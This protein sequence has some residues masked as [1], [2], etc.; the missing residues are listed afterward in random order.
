MSTEQQEED[1]FHLEEVRGSHSTKVILVVFHKKVFH[2]LYSQ[3]EAVVKSLIKIRS[4]DS[5][6]KSLVF[7]TW[8]GNS[9]S[10]DNLL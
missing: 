8:T 7:S 9:A 2:F 4:E 5:E 10:W 1:D 6:A 3:V